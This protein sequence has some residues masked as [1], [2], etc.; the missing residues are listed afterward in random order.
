MIGGEAEKT[1]RVLIPQ[2]L[3]NHVTEAQLLLQALSKLQNSDVTCLR[4]W[5][6]LWWGV[7]GGSAEARTGGAPW[8]YD[9]TRALN[10]C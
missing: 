2:T 4:V 6:L 10:N 7:Q 5:W 9:L 3:I 1:V 8:S